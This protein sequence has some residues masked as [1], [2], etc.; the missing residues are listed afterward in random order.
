MATE[1]F[2]K[3]SGDRNIQGDRYIMTEL[4]YKGLDCIISYTKAHQ[5]FNRS[6]R[7]KVAV[8]VQRWQRNIKKC[9]ACEKDVVLLIKTYC[10]FDA[11]SLP[12]H[13]DFLV[14]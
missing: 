3:L 7:V 2:G 13:Y 5:S 1:N 12:F 8:D 10:F 4:V 9:A 6:D 14:G 11:S